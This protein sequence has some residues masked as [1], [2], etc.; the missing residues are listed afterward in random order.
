MNDQNTLA[1]VEYID[2]EHYLESWST[3]VKMH[4]NKKAEHK[5]LIQK[6]Q[7]LLM[8]FLVQRNNQN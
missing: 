6:I 1:T 4:M 5:I 8:V 7:T 2:N 3:H